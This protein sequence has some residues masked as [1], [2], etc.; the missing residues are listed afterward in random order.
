MHV[1]NLQ[2]LFIQLRVMNEHLVQ[3][4]AVREIWWLFIYTTWEAV[5]VGCAT[6]VI[7][8]VILA[9]TLFSVYISNFLV[10]P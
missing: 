3:L 4:D 6:G 1:C 10:K 2:T 9:H 7:L 5:G 8:G